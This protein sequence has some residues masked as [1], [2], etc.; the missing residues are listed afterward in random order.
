MKVLYFSAEDREHAY[1][2]DALPDMEF[3]FFS[4][5]LDDNPDLK[6]DSAEVISVF[7]RSQVSKDV[8]DRFPKLK[9]I[10][11]RTTGFDHIDLEE[12]KRRGIKVANVPVY[13]EHTVAEYTF[14][15]ILALSRKVYDA[16][17]RIAET[18][19][20]SKNGLRGFDL[21]GKTLGVVGTGNI[22]RHVIKMAKGFEMDVVAFDVRRD[23]ALAHEIGFTYADFDELLARSDIITLHV[24]YNVH[25]H[26][27][28]NQ[29][30]VDKIKRG[31][32][33]INTARGAVVETDA[34]VRAL[35]EKR[36]AGAGLDVLEEE[37]VMGEEATAIFTKHPGEDRLRRVLENHYL[38]DHPNVIITP[39]NAFNTN[40]ALDRILDTTIQN[41]RSFVERGTPVYA[42]PL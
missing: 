25:T 35:Q 12:A 38:I 41:I 29:Q 26:Y 10:A 9:L 27:L 24:P 34:L 33:L 1:M 19:S 31:A 2:Q 13:G 30:N 3:E 16:Y 15:L 36:L 42:V 14:A 6:D 7:T 17:H 39:H 40:E 22:G 4:G 23:E 28:I 8:M 20:F 11:T 37:G 32:Y 18:G 5:T 21:M